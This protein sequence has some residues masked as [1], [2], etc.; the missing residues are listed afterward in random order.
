MLV[1]IHTGISNEVD[2]RRLVRMGV[3]MMGDM[4]ICLKGMIL[5][6]LI[7]VISLLPR[8]KEKCEMFSLLKCVQKTEQQI[9]F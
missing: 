4:R 7:M 1:K 9:M 5:L 8:Q 3:K 6:R 2:G